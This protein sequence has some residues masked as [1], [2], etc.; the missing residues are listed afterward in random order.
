[1]DWFT[2]PTIFTV[3]CW[4]AS[5]DS[6]EKNFFFYC[7]IQ[8]KTEFWS[9]SKQRFKKYNN[10]PTLYQSDS[11]ENSPMCRVSHYFVKIKHTCLWM[12]TQ[13]ACMGR[14]R[15]KS[16][17]SLNWKEEMA[18]GSSAATVAKTQKIKSQRKSKKSLEPG[19]KTF[20][21]LV[22]K[23][24]MALKKCRTVPNN[25]NLLPLLLSKH[26]RFFCLWQFCY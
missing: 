23:Q 2:M 21:I 9:G 22:A 7:M 24:I 5:V 3:W 15:G 4:L 18:S 20:G 13:W 12:P 8:L 11:L 6:Y 19:W 26:N 25:S 16:C 1:M 17:S 14:H 10:Q